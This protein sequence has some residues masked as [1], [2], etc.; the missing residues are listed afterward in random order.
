VPAE[1]G[2]WSGDYSEVVDGQQGVKPAQGASMLRF[3]R[4]DHDGSTGPRPRRSGD[5]MR[6]VD[7]RKLSHSIDQGAVMVSLSAV[8][9]AAEF[10]EVERYDGVVTIYA[11]DDDLDLGIATEDVV[12]QEAIAFT[13]GDVKFLDRDPSTWQPATARLMLPPATR[14]VLLKVTVRRMPV[15]T[16]GLDSLPEKVSFAAH[17]VDDIQAS[18]VIAEPLAAKEKRPSP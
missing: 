4:S 14:R 18:L 3:L 9:D 17:Y 2:R 11:L 8:F 10:P 12:Q 7:V 15:G 6:V 5:I 13:S 1:P 16:K